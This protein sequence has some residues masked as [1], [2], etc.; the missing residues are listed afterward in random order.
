MYRDLIDSV[1]AAGMKKLAFCNQKTGK[2]FIASILAGFFVGLGI[3]LIFSISGQLGAQ[4]YTKIIMG[5]SFGVALSLVIMAGSELFTGNNFVLGV[6]LLDKKAKLLEVI[7]L[8][9]VCYLGNLVG[10]ILVSF[11]FVQAGLASTGENIASNDVGMALQNASALKMNGSFLTLFVKG[12]LCNILVCLAVLCS[13]KLKSESAKLIM[14]WWCLFTFITCGYEHSVANMTIFMSSLLTP[15][16]D[17]VSFGGMAYNLLATTSGN[18]VGGLLL[19]AGYY[20]ASL[21]NN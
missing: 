2:Y 6:S 1:S 10:A 13:I 9:I 15:H 3:L 19:A 14:I 12:I 8:W 16:I 5:V 7:K 18:L 17:T 21:K 20:F 4:P 11:L